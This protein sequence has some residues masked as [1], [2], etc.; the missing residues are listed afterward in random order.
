VLPHSVSEKIVLA[1]WQFS[2]HLHVKVKLRVIG[3]SS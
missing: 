1:K 3:Y 2:W